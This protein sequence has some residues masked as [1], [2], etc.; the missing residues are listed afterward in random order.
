M[1]RRYSSGLG[2]KSSLIPE[3]KTILQTVAHTASFDDARRQVVDN[4]ILLKSTKG[5]SITIWEIVHRRYLTNKPTSVVKGLGQLSQKP[6]VDKDVELILFYELALSLPIVYDLTTDCLYTLY[7]NGRSTVNKSDILDWLDQ[8]AATGHDEINGWSPQTKSKV[9]SNYLTI[10]RDFGLLEGTQ[11]KA[12]AR[13][14]LPLATFVYVL[15][16][17]KDQGLNAKAIVTSPDFKLFLL[18]QRDV[19]LLLEEAT[20]AGYITF[21]QA[22]DIYN[23][24]FHY[25]D[26][27][28]V[29]DELI[30][31]I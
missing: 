16:R 13:L 26:L 29:I 19:F 9:A 4:N 6:T 12:F 17:L 31:Q 24:T 25:H 7:Q 30:G 20:R 22:G 5:N 10:A 1:M 18:E 23:L 15:Y 11:R 21:Q 28:E 2:G 8:A 14:Y 27:N 3:T